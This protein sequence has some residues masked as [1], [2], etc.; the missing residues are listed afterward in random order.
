MKGI[1]F[2]LLIAA[3]VAASA[4]VVGQTCPANSQTPGDPCPG[5]ASSQCVPS[6][7]PAG[8][9]VIGPRIPGR[10]VSAAII[11]NAIT[12]AS[13][14][15]P[16]T[17]CVEPAT[18]DVTTTLNFEGKPI[19][20]IAAKGAT[21][22]G[23][24]KV[25]VVEFVSNESSLS[26]LDGFT[27][28]GGSATNGDGGGILIINA[29]PTIKNC[30]ITGN[31]AASGNFPR[32]GGLWVGGS[33][34]APSIL[35]DTLTNNTSG[36]E[37]GG[38]ETAYFAHPNL[39]Y[40]TFQ[41]NTAPYGGGFAADFNGGAN[42]E[43]SLF[44]DNSASVDGGAI[45]VLTEFGHTFV[46]RSVFDGNNAPDNGSAAWVAAGFAT[47]LNSSFYNNSAA[48]G[49]PANGGAVAAGFGSAVSVMSSIL[50]SNCSVVSPTVGVLEV[51]SADLADNSSL[52]NTYNMFGNNFC[53]NSLN[54][55][56]CAPNNTNFDVIESYVGCY[57]LP[58][59]SAC[60]GKGMPDSL[61]NNAY[62]GARNDCGAHGGPTASGGLPP[63]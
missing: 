14:S 39:D 50:E 55:L 29:S 35:C 26:T 52:I 12:A 10:V 13:A 8:S 47:F 1:R 44:L 38:L 22:K 18:Y 54:T 31:T 49:A 45:H 19:D 3:M 5:A 58:P 34:A 21:L 28:T 27:V 61:F 20:L 42:I 33:E 2:F 46:R 37:G 23:N 63:L 4:P 7:C 15:V 48:I 60:V 53:T 62:D 43:N 32:G 41:G 30:Q 17:I 9:P 6:K 16:S 11:Q 24:G 40:D 25:T 56:P 36:Y 59:N 57:C 51:S